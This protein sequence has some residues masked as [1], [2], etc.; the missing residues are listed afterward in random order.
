MGKARNFKGGENLFELAQF[1]IDENRQ[2]IQ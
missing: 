2:Y 1:Y